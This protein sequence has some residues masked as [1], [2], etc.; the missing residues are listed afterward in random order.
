MD[1]IYNNNSYLNQNPDW[2]QEDSVFKKA[3][4]SGT[5]EFLQFVLFKNLGIETTSH[6]PRYELGSC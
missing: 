3:V 5:L 6:L 4:K 1:D 2:H